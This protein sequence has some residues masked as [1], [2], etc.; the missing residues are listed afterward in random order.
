[1]I[2]LERRKKQN[3]YL[4]RETSEKAKGVSIDTR[5]QEPGLKGTVSMSVE[6]FRSPAVCDSTPVLS[7]FKSLTF[8]YKREEKP[9]DR[10]KKSYP[11]RAKQLNFFSSV[12]EKWRVDAPP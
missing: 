8:I 12:T 2:G 6:H 11:R 10:S 3:C 5:R 1:M 4:T 9:A 7:T